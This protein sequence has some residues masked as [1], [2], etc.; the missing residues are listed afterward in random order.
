M[1]DPELWMSYKDTVDLLQQVYTRSSGKIL[2][3]PVF[4][5]M[6]DEQVIGVLTETNQFIMISEPSEPED[7]GIPVLKDENYI[8]ADKVFAKKKQED[9]VRT[10]TIRKIKLE[11]QFYGAFRTTVRI[12]LNESGNI[13]HKQQIM[14]LVENKKNNVD[15]QDLIET[16]LHIMCDNYVAF[17]EFDEE[18]LASLEEIS[19]CYL[20]PEDKKYCVLNNGIHQLILPK[21]HLVSGRSNADI[22]FSRIADELWR[23]KR[24]QLF[25]MNS[26]MYLNLT[27]TEYKINADEMLL[28]E[29]LLTPEYFKSLEPYQHGDTLITYET[30]N[31]ILTQKYNN[32]VSRKIQTELVTKDT[33][34]LGIDNNL[35]IE[36]VHSEHPVIGK[37]ETSVWKKFFSSKSVEMDL[38][39]TVKCSY[40]PIIYVYNQ[41]YNTFLTVEQIKSI[42]ITEYSNYGHHLY[43]ILMILR[44]QGKRD[45]VDDII[46]GKYTLETVIF[47]EVYF[48]T[49]LDLWVLAVG[50]KLPIVLFHQSKLKNLI[51]SVN[52]LRLY[53]SSVYHFVRVPTGVDAASNF[54]PQYSIVKPAINATSPE[55]IRL[56]SQ[57]S[58]KSMISLYDYFQQLKMK[59]DANN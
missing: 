27:N 36:C 39:K 37:K 25:M 40:Y 17:K 29:S 5:I 38:H 57:G 56:F 23:Y 35:K 24:I 15:S 41:L 42:L 48:L 14:K 43:K 33:S 7:D 1:D 4:K 2:S 30:A 49:P 21:F 46:K 31:P 6:E 54:L 26:K 11:T 28:L 22:Y 45:M 3:R 47:T 9:P 19:D 32:E 55:L 20:N 50:L 59:P 18:T 34:K 8:I 10:E 12:L 58:D 52:W 16:I 13:H 53:E 44:K 51:D